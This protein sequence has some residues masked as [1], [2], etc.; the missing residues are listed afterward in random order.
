M[1][2]V[3]AVTDADAIYRIDS[4]S[5]DAILGWLDAHWPSEWPMEL[6][7]EGRA[8]GRGVPAGV[9]LSETLYKC[10]LDPIDGTRGLIYDKRPAWVLS[11]VAP[12]RGGDNRLS[13][14]TVAV[15]TEIPTRKQWRADQISALRGAGRAGIASVSLDVRG[16]GRL[17][18]DVQPSTADGF[19]HGFASIARF[20]P[21]GKGLLAELEEALWGALGLTGSSFPL[22]FDDQYICT[23]GQLYELAVGHDRMLG[24]LR[25]IVYR[26]LGLDETIA[27]HPYDICTA[28]VLTEA[29]GVLEAPDGRPL[30]APLD[31]TSAVAWMGYA[32]ETLAA[33]VRPILRRLLSERFGEPA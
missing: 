5:D 15:M 20:F 30:D 8:R 13:D 4:V 27:C 17:P 33:R 22:V 14:L 26:K 23:G 3:T 31:T 18:L 16:G 25:P 19:R 6:V 12:Q 1:A 2:E 10:I 21:D 28:L 11:A 7:M 9:P 24:D 29:G 32:N